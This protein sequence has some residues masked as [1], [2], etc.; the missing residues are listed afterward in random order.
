MDRIEELRQNR[1][2]KL[3]HLR[4]LGHATYPQKTGR[5]HSMEEALNNFK[6]F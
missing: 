2:E 5:T 1:I 6:N 3:K 4:K